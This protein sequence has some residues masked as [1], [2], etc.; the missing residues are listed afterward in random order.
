MY[1]V[2]YD[3][4]S[5]EI[6]GIFPPD[7]NYEDIPA[8]KIEI[9]DAE[10]EQL[11]GGHWLVDN[12][13]LAPAT[14]TASEGWHIV[15][16]GEG[17]SDDDVVH[18]Y[19]DEDYAIELQEEY[20]SKFDSLKKSYTGAL[21]LDDAT[22]QR[23]IKRDYKRLLDEF[24]EVQNS[25]EPEDGEHEHCEICGTILQGRECPNCYWRQ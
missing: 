25:Y 13:V 8:P 17:S 23:D 14:Y 22:A 4:V 2:N 24:R 10:W 20:T 19:E 15:K 21:I 12:G 7:Y 1:Y 18:N 9:T 16:S 5:G 11:G 3:E 6:L